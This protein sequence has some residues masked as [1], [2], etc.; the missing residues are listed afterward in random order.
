LARRAA[1]WSDAPTSTGTLPAV[2]AQLNQRVLCR[3]GQGVVAADGCVIAA[4]DH[5]D[6]LRGLAACGC[7]RRVVGGERHHARGVVARHGPGAGR[8]ERER[9]GLAGKVI[10]LRPREICH[11]QRRAIAYGGRKLAC[12]EKA[13]LH[14]H[15]RGAK[16][17][18][19]RGLCAR[20]RVAEQK[21][22][23][24]L[25]PRRRAVR[26]LG[27]KRVPGFGVVA[28][29]VREAPARAQQP[30]RT[31]ERLARRLHGHAAG[32]GEEVHKHGRA[33]P[34]VAEPAACLEQRRRVV[35]PARGK[36]PATGARRLPAAVEER[37]SREVY[38]HKRPLAREAHHNA[39]VWCVRVHQR[40]RAPVRK[41]PV[42]HGVL[43]AQGHELRVSQL[44][45]GAARLYCHGGTG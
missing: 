3:E 44:F 25:G 30:R 29:P 34:H 14:V 32:A 41:E 12:G 20:P 39:H 13:R 19:R 4:Q 40:P 17:P 8:E 2:P 15:A 42:C 5:G 36:A 7:V 16:R 6:R 10:R 27:G 35:C 43:R 26:G 18:S 22:H 11:H 24:V 37:L 9:L 1:N 28:G 31:V 33:V 38:A 23:A 21:L 45:V